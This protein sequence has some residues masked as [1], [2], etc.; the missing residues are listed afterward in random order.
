M[1]SITEIE[2][3]STVTSFVNSEIMIKYIHGQIANYSSEQN[4]VK[5]NIYKH[6]VYFAQCIPQ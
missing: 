2:Y 5:Y 4:K 6:V 1:G 3:Y